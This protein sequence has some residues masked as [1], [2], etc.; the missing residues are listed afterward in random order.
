M[1][2]T[3]ESVSVLA[4]ALLGLKFDT[5]VMVFA[6]RIQAELLRMGYAVVRLDEDGGP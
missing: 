5:D 6:P 3:K 1:L 2:S 4:A